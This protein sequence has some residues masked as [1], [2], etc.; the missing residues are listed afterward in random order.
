[1]GQK[2]NLNQLPND[3]TDLLDTLIHNYPLLVKI[4]GEDNVLTSVFRQDDVLDEDRRIA[5]QLKMADWSSLNEAQSRQLVMLV[6]FM[7]VSTPDHQT[8]FWCDDIAKLAA[9]LRKRFNT[10]YGRSVYA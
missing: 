3:T 6:D 5:N 1:M 8:A 4:S 7:A 10:A 2:M 9:L